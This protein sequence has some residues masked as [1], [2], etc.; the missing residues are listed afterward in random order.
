MRSSTSPASSGPAGSHF[1]GQVAASYLLAMLTR[2]EPRGLPSTSI[3]RV[4]FQRA[5]ENHPL[6]DVIVHAHD[7]SGHPAVLEVQVKRTITFA[8]SDPVFQSV[9]QQI[10]EAAR[11]PGFWTSRHELAVATAHTSRKIA[12]PYQDVLTWARQLDS[13]TIFM[14]RIERPGSA[15]DDMRTFVGTFRSHLALAGSPID[16]ETVWKLL[17]RLQIL[18]FDYTAPGSAHEDHAKER[19]ARALHPDEAPGAGALWAT[20]VELA[21]ETAASGGD[22]TRDRLVEDLVRRSFRFSGDRRYANARAALA[23]ASRQALDD[24]GNQVRHTKLTRHERIA[25]VRA[26][27]Y[28]MR[29]QEIRGDA[30]VGKSGLLRHFAE[31]IGEQGRIV[32]LSPGRTTPRGWIALRAVLGF[33]G[34]ARDLLLDLA[35]DGGALLCIDNLDFFNDEERK[36][37]IDLLRAAAGISGIA[38]LATA[39]RAFGVDEPSWL[40]SDVLDQLGRAEPVVIGELSDSEVDELRHAAPEL[41]P[42]LAD[43]HPAR[44]VTRNLFRLGRLADRPA[45]A[46]PLRS[47]IDMAEHWW[48][49]GD[50][51]LDSGHRDR[52]RVLR[53]LAEQALM[54]ADPLEVRDHPSQAIGALIGSESLRDLGNDHVAFRHDVLREWAIANLLASQP[55]LLG[56]L[57]L[58]R[59]ASAGFA[60]AVELTAR[61]SLERSPDGSPWRTLLETVCREGAHGSWRRAVL[62]ALVRSEVGNE[63]LTRVSSQLLAQQASLLR[64]LIR[65]VMAVDVEPAGKLLAAAGAD[66]ASIPASITI[67]SGPSWYRLILWV[68]ALGDKLPGAAI[69]DVVDLYSGWSIGTLGLDPLT[70]VVLQRVHAWLVRIETARYAEN[71]HERRRPFGEELDSDRTDSLENDLRSTFLV[72]SHRVPKLAA[73]YLQALMQRSRGKDVCRK[74]LKFRGSLAQ[75]APTEL[76]ELTAVTLIAKGEGRTR[77]QHRRDDE[78]ALNYVDKEFLPASPAQGPFFEL[79]THAPQ[80]G[81]A[82]IR[83]LVDH[84]ISSQAGA[85][86]SD[87]DAFLLHFPTGDRSFPWVH[88]YAWARHARHYSVTSALM[89]LEAWAH[90]RIEA[91]EP[92]DTVLADVISEAEAPAAY[93]LV[94]V[95]LLLSHWRKSREAAVPFLSCPELLC[96]DR[97]RSIHDQTEHPDFFGLK[98]LQKEPASAVSIEHL[99]ARPSRR[100]TLDQFLGLYAV[101]GNEGLRSTLADALRHASKRLGPPDD[102]SNLGDPRLMVIHALNLIEPK[103]YKDVEVE[104]PDGTKVKARQYVS[105]PDEERRFKSLQ[106]TSR[107]YFADANMQAFLNLALNDSSRSSSEMIEAAIAWAQKPPHQ[108]PPDDHQRVMH[109]Q[110]IVTAAMVAMRD[111]KAEIRAGH[112]EWATGIFAS[113]LQ[114][115]AD[116]VYSHRS[117]LRFNPVAIAFVGMVHGLEG[118]AAKEDLRALLTVATRDDAAA[119]H[120]LTVTSASLNKIDARLPR[121]LLR[122][123]LAACIKSH[124]AWDLSASE[125]AARAT[126][127]TERLESAVDAEMK[128]LYGAAAEPEWPAFPLELPPPKRRMRIGGPREPYPSPAHPEPSDQYVDHHAAAVWINNTAVSI[129]DSHRLW[130]RGL[131]QAYSRWTAS[132]NGADLGKNEDV[133][134]TP[135]EWN[136]TY[137]ALLAHCLPGMEMAEIQALALRP[138]ASLPDDAFLEVVAQFVRSSD[139]VYFRDNAIDSTTATAVRSALADRLMKTRGWRRLAGDRSTGIEIRLG[140]G[141]AVFFF[142][143]QSFGQ[144]PKCY[145]YKPAIPRTDE[146]LP[147]LQ[148]LVESAPCLFVAIIALNLLEVA[149]RSEQMPL[150][151]TGVKA[152]LAS[153]PDDRTFWTDHGIGRRTCAWIEM[154]KETEPATLASDTSIRAEVDGILS[155]LV[156]LGVAEATRLEV[157]LGQ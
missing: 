99:K 144:S 30:G 59:P 57:P 91:G 71:F 132:M 49:T 88:S 108:E 157:V 21:L 51:K 65:L 135:H 125:M 124:H 53:A 84:V 40:P 52:T 156:A 145:L 153:Y 86:P 115:K 127:R 95:D 25:A 8:P 54:H 13:H 55:D 103:N 14:A 92:F 98:A 61:F 63:L 69:P 154:I 74:I 113:A 105:P 20:L 131:V 118:Q 42:L 106:H 45:D 50:G 26:S 126:A 3:D 72:F 141:G 1:E 24:I 12:G 77:R 46:P 67:P 39:R 101:E 139:E 17:S 129:N 58:Q 109:Q 44:S 142:N 38:V 104:Q 35:A 85:R 16:D 122:V 2:A 94:A 78:E 151:L 83:R 18:V 102:R 111:G 128:W 36:T 43:N 47:E 119:A 32:V 15:N 90:R 155:A 130:M 68:L 80:Q 112:R 140:P 96:L 19:A 107:D 110:A 6:D 5:H 41:A 116:H 79:L 70:P 23:E 60:R 73:Q 133:A 48:S 123:A 75:A 11:R 136:N 134:N 93:L 29:Y 137:F 56:R 81:L 138:I 66:P 10:A 76:A 120:A 7:A 62:L 4:E 9:V 121:A 27:N 149:P 28:G 64:E 146:F 89:A 148:Q 97:Q 87:T 82:L 33:D 150:L 152:W 100:Y 147:V 22:R 31:Q 34:S 37:V 117:G 114:S 143:D